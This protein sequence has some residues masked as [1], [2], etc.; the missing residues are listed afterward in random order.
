MARDSDALK[1]EKWA[2]AGDVQ[3][4]E[5]GGV[6]R[7]SGWDATYSQAGG[8][9]PKREHFNQII[10]E[11]SGLGV[12][13]NTHG[14]LEWDSTV[15]YVHP[16]LVF[17]SDGK[18]YV[19]VADTTDV[20]PVTD[21]ANAYWKLYEVQGPK[22]DKGD[23]GDRGLDATVPDATTTAK[24]KV[25]LATDAEAQAGADTER[26]VT[27]ASLA[28]RTATTTRA[29]L[30]EKATQAEA[31]AGTD[32]E[33]YVTPALVKRRIDARG[34]R[35]TRFTTVGTHT[36]TPQVNSSFA[37]AECI[38]G[39]GGGGG[40]ADRNRGADGGSGGTGGGRANSG[41]PY[42]TLLHGAVT[43]VVGAGGTR[44]LGSIGVA[45]TAGGNG[46][47]STFGIG[48]NALP[49]EFQVTG[50]RG[51]GGAAAGN[52]FTGPAGAAGGTTAAGSGGGGGAGLFAGSGI[53]AGGA[54]GGASGPTVAGGAG[55]TGTTGPVTGSGT[56]EGAGGGGGGG[57]GADS[58]RPSAFT[59][60]AGGGP[61]GGGG[62]G[63]GNG[64][65]LGGHPGA[66]GGLGAAGEVRIWEW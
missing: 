25:E 41:S 61:G 30:V 29:G 33:R 13:V 60:A 53:T 3:D 55:G 37:F 21:T 65:Y 28:S 2:A 34:V 6:T 59:G 51:L 19:S 63:G 9:L 27:P 66:N 62:G 14:L 20:D 38:G 26:V 7:S 58:K 1:I 22:G 31:D 39:G 10:R 15:S 56:T 52:A 46:G 44:G 42:F 54:G 45:A 49:T 32:S 40:G 50:V 4:P 35:K 64:H 18:P 5:D 47:N 24:G 57:Q 23:T 8:N 16:A 43:V 48:A 36:W 12:E 11:L 17:G